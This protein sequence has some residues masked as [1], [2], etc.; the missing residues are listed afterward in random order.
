M[1][2]EVETYLSSLEKKNITSL[3]IEYINIPIVGLG[4]QAA[5][6]SLKKK[7]RNYNEEGLSPRE[8]KKNS[9]LMEYSDFPEVH[10][11]ISKLMTE[12]YEFMTEIPNPDVQRIYM[13]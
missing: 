3:F 11:Q 1:L 6:K 5:S 9:K 13:P 12:N 2:G 7:Y 8:K 4:T 10:Q